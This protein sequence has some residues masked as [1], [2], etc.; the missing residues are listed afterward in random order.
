M[1]VDYGCRN[2][3]L[4]PKKRDSLLDDLK[5]HF[6]LLSRKWFFQILLDVIGKASHRG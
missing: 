4:H 5:I 3:G 2:N 6:A 1:F